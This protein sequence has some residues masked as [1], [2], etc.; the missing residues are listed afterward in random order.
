MTLN[1]EIERQARLLACENRAAEPGIRKVLWF[2]D[3]SEIR[4]VSLLDEFPTSEDGELHPFYFR[5]SPEDGLTSPSGVT[6]IRSDE[7][8]K[9]KLPPGWGD[10]DDAIEL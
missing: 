10:W 9:L 3:D 1:K 7:Y 4:L 5:P 2:P 6:L 8:R